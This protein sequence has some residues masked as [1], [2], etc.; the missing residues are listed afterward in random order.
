MKTKKLDS[1]DKRNQKKHTEELGLQLPEDYFSKS[2]AAILSQVLNKKR[3]KL[4]VFSRKTIVWSTTIAAMLILT[5][6]LFRQNNFSATDHITTFVSDSI[7]AFNPK[8]ITKNGFETTKED[9]LL[10]SLFVD[11]KHVNEYVDN[12]IKEKLINDL[13]LSE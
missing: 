2:K 4:I 10:A 8:L 12:Y 9:V 11:D 13:L 5:I 6:T 3:S 1:F 7:D